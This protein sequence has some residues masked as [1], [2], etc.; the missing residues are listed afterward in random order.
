MPNLHKINP[1]PQQQNPSSNIF[2]AP[3]AS[4]VAPPP[5]LNPISGPGIAPSTTPLISKPS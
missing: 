5:S 2:T 4:N 1:Q 3:I